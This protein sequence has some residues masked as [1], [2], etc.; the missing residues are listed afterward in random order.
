MLSSLRRGEASELKP[1]QC[2]P[3]GTGAFPFCL[4]FGSSGQLLSTLELTI[5]VLFVTRSEAGDFPKPSLLR[6]EVQFHDAC[7][8]D[9]CP[10]DKLLTSRQ[11]W[12]MVRKP[13][14]RGFRGN[15]VCFSTPAL[16]PS[17]GGR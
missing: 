2:L 12:A 1:T 15:P 4:L 5:C 11:E 7:K 13:R 16:R 8:A 9:I 3:D 6:P 17:P 14:P 10:S